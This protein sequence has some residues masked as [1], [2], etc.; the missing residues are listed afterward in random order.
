VARSRHQAV[1]FIARRPFRARHKAV[2]STN[3]KPVYGLEE[4]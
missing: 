2:T 1:L 3:Q 4:A